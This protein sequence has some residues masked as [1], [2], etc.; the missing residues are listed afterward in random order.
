MSYTEILN[1]DIAKNKNVIYKFTNLIN[2]KVYIGQT[3]R[4]FRERLAQHV[5]RMNNDPCYFHK[6]L[7]KYGLS[8]F[9]ITILETCENPE[10]LNGLEIYWIDYY[11]SN[12]RDYGYNLTSGGSNISYT[13]KKRYEE[14]EET[15]IKRSQSAKKKWQDPE[16]RKRY[17]KSRKDYIKIVKLSIDNE[18]IEIYPTFADAET[19]MFG[20]R[21]GS[22][23]YPLRKYNK[24]SI[25]MKGFKWMTLDSYNKV[26]K[27]EG[28]RID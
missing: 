1:S 23:W 28:K 4:Q 21:N 19:S 9:D 6:A 3:R 8:N 24:E 20:K 17:K 7:S 25:E 2:N 12:N 18:L 5:Y 10:D 22:L 15:R 11:K 13:N 26:M 27:V 14:K 16:Y